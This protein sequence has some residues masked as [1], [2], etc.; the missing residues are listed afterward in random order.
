MP[1]C[2]P[3]AGKA[4]NLI[5]PG[6]AARVQ[7]RDVKLCKA[8]HLNEPQEKREGGGEGGQPY[9][10]QAPQ[11]CLPDQGTPG[12]MHFRTELGPGPGDLHNRGLSYP[13]RNLSQGEISCLSIFQVKKLGNLS[14]QLPGETEDLPQWIPGPVQWP[15]PM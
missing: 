4:I 12:D 15:L 6:R 2:P 14:Q 5:Y 13:G 11:L 3:G 10:F 8:E 1:A 7:G 9:A